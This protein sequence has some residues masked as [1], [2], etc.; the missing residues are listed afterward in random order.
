MSTLV[1]QA[2]QTLSVDVNDAETVPT[3][4]ELE[5][6]FALPSFVREDELVLA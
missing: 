6:L 3:V 4:A 2:Y 1:K 5:E